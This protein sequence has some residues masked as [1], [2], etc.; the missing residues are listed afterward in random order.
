M[1][2]EIVQQFLLRCF[3]ELDQEQLLYVV[4]RNVEELPKLLPRDDVDFVVRG[5]D[6][7]KFERLFDKICREQNGLLVFREIVIGSLQLVYVIPNTKNE[8]ACIRIDIKENVNYCGLVL[9]TAEEI[10]RHR[11]R[12]QNTWRPSY[13]YESISILFH[14]VLDKSYFRERYGKQILKLRN[15]DR[16]GFAK[17]L[18]S[19]ICK[20]ELQWIEDSLNRGDFKNL[21]NRRRLVDSLI[22]KRSITRYFIW[23]WCVKEVLRLCK[24]ALKRH[25]ALIVVLGPDGA[26]KSTLNDN[27]FVALEKL[28]FK[29]ERLYFGVRAP[30]FPTKRILRFF[31][32]K[33]RP[34]NQRGLS[35]EPTDWK[36]RW[37]LFLG[38]LHT[39]LDQNFRYWIYARILLARGR[40]ILCDRYHYDAVTVPVPKGFR[41]LMDFVMCY[42]VAKP[43]LSIIL[44]DDPKEIRRRKAEL[45]ITEIE[46]QQT[47]YARLC[48]APFHAKQ[49]VTD[50]SPEK[51]ALELVADVMAAFYKRNG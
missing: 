51:I 42:L 46:R 47:C 4:L 8:V 16:I 27:L 30:V 35:C 44:T 22:S 45:S 11:R 3:C 18:Q 2:R 14:A 43:D 25:G 21:H 23:K 48:K 5:E 24:L 13:E 49:I 41:F 33:R 15:K 10:I 38:V 29:V 12:W 26:G 39:L 6:V 7:E 1:Y 50:K 40:I 36:K 37:S 9:M 31:H 17:I 28:P 32:D 19:L 20:K 34:A